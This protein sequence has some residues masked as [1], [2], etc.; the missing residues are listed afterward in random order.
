V[1]CRLF[2]RPCGWWSFRIENNIAAPVIVAIGV[3]ARDFIAT[4]G[5]ATRRRRGEQ[6]T[7][8]CWRCY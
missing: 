6:S 1:S 5:R 4:Y 7:H 3:E 2:G 8:C